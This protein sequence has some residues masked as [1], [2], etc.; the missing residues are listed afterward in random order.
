MH[1]LKL[2]KQ[3]QK[4]R[5][6]LASPDIFANRTL[7]GEGGI[8]FQMT[9]AQAQK[10]IR[11]KV[12]ESVDSAFGVLRKRIDKFGVTQPNIQK[13]GESGRILVELPGAKD[14]D[15]IKKLLQS[16]AQ[17]EFWETYKIDEI[18]NFLMAANEALKKTEINKVETKV[19][20]KDSIK[21]FID[22][23]KRFSCN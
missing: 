10:V 5:V 21:C 23:W 11:K 17:L 14:V 15:R 13:L 16:T 20:P 18:G 12:D 3:I 2:L 8:D 19:T 6:K 1:S 7:Q 9:D 22:N 4:E